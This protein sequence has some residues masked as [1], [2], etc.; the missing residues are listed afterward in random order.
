MS[1][2]TP[3]APKV[4]A[5]KRPAYR[6]PP[7]KAKRPAKKVQ[8]RTLKVTATVLIGFAVLFGAAALASRDPE[9]KPE[10]V[11][12]FTAELAAQAISTCTASSGPNTN[13][14]LK[15]SCSDLW[16]Q[17]HSSGHQIV[18]ADGG[19]LKVIEAPR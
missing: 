8:H 6:P 12:P 3:T 1:R 14:A 17:L 9:R 11:T 4:A 2:R 18:P 5:R 16:Q 13:D 10:P 19:G 7:A 15:E